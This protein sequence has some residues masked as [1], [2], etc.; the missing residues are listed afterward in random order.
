MRLVLAA[1]L[2][3]LF[4]LMTTPAHGQVTF[5]V[6]GNSTTASFTSWDADGNKTDNVYVLCPP[7]AK[8]KKAYREKLDFH[9]CIG[10]S[11]KRLGAEYTLSCRE[12]KKFNLVPAQ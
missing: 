11:V 10:P 6:C 5:K 8:N 7:D 9:G 1:L 3:A 12:W 2:V 4:A